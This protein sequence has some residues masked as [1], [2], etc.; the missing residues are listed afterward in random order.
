MAPCV[1]FTLRRA[2]EQAEE[3]VTGAQSPYMKRNAGRPGAEGLR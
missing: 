2:K 3:L 1:A